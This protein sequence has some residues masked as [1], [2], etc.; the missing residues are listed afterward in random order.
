M[1]FCDATNAGPRHSAAVHATGL[2]TSTARASAWNVA[3]VAADIAT[4]RTC[5]ASSKRAGASFMTAAIT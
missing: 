2:R 3:T 1:R 5:S 4:H